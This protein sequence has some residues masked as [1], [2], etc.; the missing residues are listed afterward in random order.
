ME[1][2]SNFNMTQSENTNE[3][4]VSLVVITY[5]SAKTVLETLDS[6]KAQTY[7]NIELIISDDCSKDNTVEIIKGWFNQNRSRFVY[8]ELV[9]TDINTGVSGNINR[10]IAKSHGEWIKS[11]AGDDLLIPT[12][13]EEYVKY[14]TTSSEKI[15]MCVCDVEPF[16]SDGTSV[17]K[18]KIEAYNKYL[19]CEKESLEYQKERILREL[20]FVGPTYFYSRELYDEVG[21]FL[22][23]YGMCEEW[24]FVYKV[25]RGGNRIYTICKKLVLYRISEYSLCNYRDDSGLGSPR[26]FYSE[27]KFF[28][29]FPFKDLLRECKYLEAW[30]YYLYYKTAKC[31]YDTGNSAFSKLLNRLY[32]YISP[33]SYLCK[34]G[35]KRK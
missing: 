31:R 25:I 19:E 33:Y 14:V 20:R 10:G 16:M 21:G 34:M 4:L 9:M 15:R 28:F 2:T 11:I 8:T 24:P 7:H 17:P 6:I 3:P 26:L 5:N 13:I 30:H 32:V 35:L 27:F 12:A 29:D 23:E 22:A 18:N 1:T